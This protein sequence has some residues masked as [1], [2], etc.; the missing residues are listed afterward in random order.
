[1]R[2]SMSCS[3]ESVFINTNLFG[4]RSQQQIIA[5]GRVHLEYIRVRAYMSRYELDS[6]CG[7]L[8]LPRD[9]P[10]SKQVH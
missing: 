9:Q 4:A 3:H 7:S 5:P 1:M 8:K 2:S 6:G 10:R